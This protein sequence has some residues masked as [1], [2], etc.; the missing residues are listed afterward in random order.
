MLLSNR[1]IFILCFLIL[2]TFF[3]IDYFD[4]HHITVTKVNNNN[5]NYVKKAVKYEDN[6]HF[7]ERIE[8]YKKKYKVKNIVACVFYGRKVYT[9]ILFRYLDSNLKING[10]ILDKIIILNH[11][12]GTKSNITI[13]SEFLRSYLNAHKYNYEEFKF[14]T[15]DT[16]PMM[17]SFLKDDDLV[18]KV[19][20]DIVF[21]A[22]NT[23][24]NM[25]EDYFTN[26]RFVLSANIINHH[27]LSGV[28]AYMNTMLPFY[29]ASNHTWNLDDGKTKNVNLSLFKKCVKNQDMW[30]KN[31]KCSAIAHE[32]FLYNIYENNFNLDIYNFQHLKF[33]NPKT[34]LNERW[35]IN[36]ILFRGRDLNKLVTLYPN[37]ISDEEIITVLLTNIK[38][39]FNFALG[40]A[41]VAHFS[42]YEHINYLKE[43]NILKKY[44]K[45]SFDYFQK[46]E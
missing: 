37:I 10:G 18:F 23:F 36:F 12:M 21:I 4:Q 38:K 31:E 46:S 17:Y 16:Y 29:E 39:K 42:Y 15:R 1:K 25:V 44:D 27:S 32:S 33:S 8:S 26:D 9:E 11:L 28:H 13:E 41:V 20:D 7:N 24:K 43:T 19:D 45:L 14:E 30:R 3:F 5:L 6:D 35:R 22:N 40:S 34:H 2:F